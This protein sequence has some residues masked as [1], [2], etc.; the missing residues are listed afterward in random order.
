MPNREA[1]AAAVAP[2]LPES[3]DEGG[4]QGASDPSNLSYVV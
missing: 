3:W 4:T 1:V 2:L